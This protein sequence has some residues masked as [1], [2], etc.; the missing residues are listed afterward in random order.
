MNLEAAVDT[1]SIMVN[2]GFWT[3]C[4]VGCLSAGLMVQGDSVAALISGVAVAPESLDASPGRTVEVSFALGAPAWMVVVV[5]GPNGEVVRKMEASSTLLPGYHGVRW[6]GRDSQGAVVPNEAYSF[7]IESVEPADDDEEC[8]RVVATYDPRDGSGGELMNPQD[9]RIRADDNVIEYVLPKPGRV[10]IRG[11]ID[12]GPML[13]TMVNWEPRPAG[14]VTESWRGYDT[15]GLRQFFKRPDAFLT[16]MAYALPD[17]SVI[18]YGNKDITYAEWYEKVGKGLP[19]RPRP[20][21]SDNAPAVMCPHSYFPPHLTTDPQIVVSFPDIEGYK[22]SA[23]KRGSDGV[24]QP[25]VISGDAVLV[26]VSIPNEAHLKFL[27][28]RQFEMVVFVDDRRFFEAEQSAAPFNFR[29]DVSMLS[30]GLHYLTMNVVSAADH[31]GTFTAP[32]EIRR[33]QKPAPGTNDHKEA[34]PPPAP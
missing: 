19:H 25:A 34:G 26:R 9:F 1:A 31:V 32:I 29:W 17:N 28:E 10:R 13:G 6:D 21:R 14:L 8:S 7:V 12:N 24:V 22:E 27:L 2:I 4:I 33:E 23:L 30:S 3:Y 18:T 11:G 20:P 5:V 16:E 15:Q